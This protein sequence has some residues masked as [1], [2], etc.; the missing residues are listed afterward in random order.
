MKKTA[1]FALALLAAPALAVATPE[2]AVHQTP[3]PTTD[4]TIP[5]RF[6]VMYVLPVQAVLESISRPRVRVTVPIRIRTALALR[7]GEIVRLK[8]GGRQ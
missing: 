2:V 3:T 7:S 8:I 5:K 6:V 4:I 1:L